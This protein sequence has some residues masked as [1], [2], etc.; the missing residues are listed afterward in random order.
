MVDLSDTGAT[1][2]PPAD[3]A[4]VT[5]AAVGD[6]HGCIG[7]LRE[8][9]ERVGFIDERGRWAAD[10]ARLWFLGDLTDRGPDGVGVLDLVMSLQ[11]QAADSGGRVG[12]LLGNHELMLLAAHL[13]DGYRLRMTRDDDE[14]DAHA[15]FRERW[16]GNG[17]QDRDSS[18]LTDGH[19]EWIAGLPAMA[20]ERE[21]LL[22][23]A[24]T[25][26]YLEYGG[27]VDAVNWSI[28]QLLSDPVDVEELDHLTH[29]MTKRFAFAADDGPSAREFLRA[30]GGRQIVHGHSPI[31]LLLGIEPSAVTGPLV[32]AGGYAVN[33][34]TGVF[35]G[36]PCLIS[37]LPSVPSQLP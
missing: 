22:V 10:D 26:G 21:H 1:G 3:D 14:P 11:E 9:L 12:C 18:R 6:V 7:P 32:Y 35:L 23:H 25:V 24:D 28:G 34:D 19:L 2:A 8:A 4:A 27:D 33:L 13:P 36:G 31:P 37:A 5:T 30:F 29:L 17:G 20:L 16:F 15:L